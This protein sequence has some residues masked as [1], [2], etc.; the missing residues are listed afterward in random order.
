MKAGLVQGRAVAVKLFIKTNP[1]TA[2]QV[3]SNSSF[4]DMFDPTHN[5]L[6]LWVSKWYEERSARVWE[7][8]NA[9]SVHMPENTN[10]VEK[11]KLQNPHQSA[12]QHDPALVIN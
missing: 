9:Q 3:V 12:C 7:Q 1:I 6:I 11:T 10:K 8:H 4:T 2:T 5:T